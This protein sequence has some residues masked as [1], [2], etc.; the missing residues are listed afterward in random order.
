MGSYTYQDEAHPPS[1]PI[2]AETESKPEP[3]A[4]DLEKMYHKMMKDMIGES[5]EAK[6]SKL[7]TEAERMLDSASKKPGVGPIAKLGEDEAEKME[8]DDSEKSIYETDSD[9]HEAELDW[10]KKEWGTPEK[11]P[12]P[13][14][15]PDKVKETEFLDF[16]VSDPSEKVSVKF[17]KVY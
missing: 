5:A 9:P 3:S 13:S 1:D 7:E 16:Y 15:N 8:E 6:L 12:S 17:V 10:M 14:S 2:P 4:E 11:L